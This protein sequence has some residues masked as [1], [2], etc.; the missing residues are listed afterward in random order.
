MYTLMCS[1]KIINNR[2]TILLRYKIKLF[3]Y[4]YIDYSI[5]SLF[6]PWEKPINSSIINNTRKITTTCP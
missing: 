4:K 3:R 5:Q 6:R 1:H 2:I